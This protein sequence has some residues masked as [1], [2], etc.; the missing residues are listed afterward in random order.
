MAHTQELKRKKEKEED[1]SSSRKKC[2]KTVPDRVVHDVLFQTTYN[3]GDE[4]RA[5]WFKDKP[6]G[7]K[8]PHKTNDPKRSSWKPFHE[9]PAKIISAVLDGCYVSNSFFPVFSLYACSLNFKVVG[10]RQLI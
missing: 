1:A 5:A 4:V 6:A 9:H 3:I 7:P 8:G 2:S 10:E